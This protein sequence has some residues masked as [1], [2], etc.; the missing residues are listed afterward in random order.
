[1]LA[2]C[3]KSAVTVLTLWPIINSARTNFMSQPPPI[4]NE[5]YLPVMVKYGE[6]RVP[7]GPSCWVLPAGD[8]LEGLFSAPPIHQSPC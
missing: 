8:D 3:T 2:T 5:M 6:V 7:W 1:M 4:R